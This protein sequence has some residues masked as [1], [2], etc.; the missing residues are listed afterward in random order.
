MA[1][2]APYRRLSD[3]RPSD[4]IANQELEQREYFERQG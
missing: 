3:D 1:G 4:S 2:R